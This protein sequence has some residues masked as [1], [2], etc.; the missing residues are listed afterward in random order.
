MRELF[1]KEEIFTMQIFRNF[2]FCTE[3]GRPRI[4]SGGD[5]GLIEASPAI[6]KIPDF[7]H[8]IP[9]TPQ[10]FP[11]LRDFSRIFLPKPNDK[12]YQKVY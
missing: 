5:L 3:T 4:W 12:K 9:G 11:F 2:R 8:L 6:R 10:F 1:L 7:P